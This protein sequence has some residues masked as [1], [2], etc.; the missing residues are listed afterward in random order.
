MS[1]KS[2]E[3]KSV[4]SPVIVQSPRHNV[5]NLTGYPRK[6]KDLAADFHN[7]VMKWEVL[8]T[9]GM[10]LVTKI[11]N[12]KIEKV[13]NLQN[14]EEGIKVST[15]PQELNPLCDD[16]AEI[17]EAMAVLESKLSNKTENAAALAELEQSH[18][19]GDTS[20]ILFATMTLKDVAATTK[21]IH[22]DFPKELQLK[23]VLLGKVAHASSREESEALAACWLHQP[24]I[25][26]QCHDLLQALLKET[27]HIK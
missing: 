10:D 9:K 12:I 6:V 20:Q 5:G 18:P 14:V 15:L 19:G 7:C 22:S 13:W 17:I 3:D 26:P 2:N 4:L 11:A 27:G 8:N 16:L 1:Q 25:R 23:R 24:Y 21:E